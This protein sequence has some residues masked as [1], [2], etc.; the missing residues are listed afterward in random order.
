MKI[1]RLAA[2]AK[3]HKSMVIINTMDHGQ[4]VRQHLMIGLA[5]YPMDGLPL[6]D[7]G[8]LLTMLD[9]PAEK[10]NEFSVCIRDMW[11]MMQWITTDNDT[12]DQEASVC[13]TAVSLPWAEVVPVY[14]QSGMVFI[15]NEYKRIIDNEKC[16]SWWSRKVESGLVLVAKK[17]YQ[18]IATIMQDNRWITDAVCEE[19]WH[20]AQAARNL[21]ERTKGNEVQY[22]QQTMRTEED[23]QMLP[24]VRTLQAPVLPGDA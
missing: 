16:V 15:G 24:D 20:I 4:I 23:P 17:G 3:E 11:D 12:G 5:V 6:L 21:Y 1:T 10:R 7:G 22:E 9:V 14:T 8:E 2:L 19:L 18:T 13:E